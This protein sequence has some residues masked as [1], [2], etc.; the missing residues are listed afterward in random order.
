[1]K[2]RPY[3]VYLELLV[4]RFD[5]LRYTHLPRV[6][7]RFVDA[8]ATLAS[9]VDIPIDI[10]ISPLLIELRTYPTYCCMIGETEKA[11]DDLPWY[12]DIYHFLKFGTYPDVVSTKD[13]RALRQPSLHRSSDERG[14]CWSLWT[15]YGRLHT[16]LKDHENWLFFVDHGD[17]LLL[18]HPKMSRVSDAWKI[19]P[20]ASNGHEFILVAIDY[21]T[22]WVE[23]TSYAKLTSTRV[24]S[25]VRSCII[26]RF[27]YL[28]SL[29]QI[30]GTLLSQ[31]ATPYSLVYGVEV[32]MLVEIEMGSLRVVLEQ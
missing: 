23:A 13:Q 21:F 9:M 1:M 20:K 11:Q 25:F 16:S 29:F 24:F 27:G 3:H 8:L 15:A 18:V 10:I 5:E 19:S 30:R 28:M 17:R 6:Q 12:Y 4:R 31:G 26:Y 14:S 22:K 32:V 2:L 7:N